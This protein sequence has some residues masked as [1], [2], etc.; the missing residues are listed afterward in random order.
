M[1][2]LDRFQTFRAVVETGSFTAA[3][4]ALEQ[5][6]AAVSFNI[7]QLEAELGVTLLTRTTRRVVLTDAGERFYQRC[8]RVLAEADL[9]IEDARGEHAGMQGSLRITSTV[10]YG[11][12]VIAPALHIF[13]GVHPALRV[14]LETHA[15]PIDLLRER[16]DVAIRLGQLDTLRDAGYR[17]TSLGAYDIRP[18]VAP[19]LLAGSART[20][21]DSPAQLAAL[22]QIGHTR[23]ERVQVW[24][25]RDRAGK[26]HVYQP[27][28]K[29][30][31]VAD[32]ASVLRAL[33]L[34]GSGVALLPEWLVRKDLA[35]GTLIDALPG[36]RF[37]Q[38][39]VHA[40]YL[41]ARHVPQKIR[42]WI[43]FMKRYLR[44]KGS[45]TP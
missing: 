24:D 31:V 14:R 21:I 27:T 35:E 19:A 29:A 17:G 15:A 23:L 7:K 30:V 41:P 45:P 32:N 11:A 5:A 44:E 28:A 40:L 9:A 4:A 8:L 25:L 42:Q 37:P 20:R 33:A 36:Y 12:M 3:A 39:G 10:E 16:F 34:Q 13:M 18:V 6:R 22:P 38:Q 2:S 1:V 43:D 26:T